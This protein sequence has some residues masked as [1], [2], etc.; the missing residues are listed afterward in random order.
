MSKFSGEYP[1]DW[2]RIALAVKEKAGWKCERC[3]HRHDPRN[4]YCLTVHHLDGD[5]SNILDWNLAALCQ[6]C[7]LA[8]QGKVNM[9]QC[10]MFEHTPWMKPHVEAME[11]WRQEMP[12]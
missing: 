10:Y 5:K 4:G 8:I 1:E 9:F 6:R 7:H 12:K 2:E 11:L 3:G